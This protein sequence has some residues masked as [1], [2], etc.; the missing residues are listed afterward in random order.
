M[1]TIALPDDIVWE[2]ERLSARLG[3]SPEEII[4]R[5]ISEYLRGSSAQPQD[6]YDSIGFGMWAGRDDME[7]SVQWV[8][9]L[10]ERE[11]SS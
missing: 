10:R 9:R 8:H 4:R 5:G 1:R 2:L 11:W 3:I 6:E 7:D